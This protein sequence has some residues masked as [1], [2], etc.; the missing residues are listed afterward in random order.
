MLLN[1]INKRDINCMPGYFD[2]YID[3]VE[4]YLNEAFKNSITN[5]W[6]I[7]LDKLAKLHSKTYESGKWTVND[8]LQHIAD[9]ERILCAGTLRFVRNE[10]DHVIRFDGKMF[11]DNV[12]ADKKPIER[13]IKE[14]IMVRKATYSLFR[15]FDENDFNK[16]GMK[17]EYHISVLAMGYNIIGH[18]IHHL[19]IIKDKYYPLV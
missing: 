17:G 18:Q 1:N 12:N 10:E 15:T 9:K 7:D 5:L 13:I 8:I 14:L 16:T 19:N 4:N 2:R 11:A 6:N 3:L